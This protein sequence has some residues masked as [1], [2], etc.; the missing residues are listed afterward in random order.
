M[1]HR[2]VGQIRQCAQ[3]YFFII[4]LI[5]LCQIIKYHTII[6]FDIFFTDFDGCKFH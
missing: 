4:V 3:L 2:T 1:A 5:T 6:D